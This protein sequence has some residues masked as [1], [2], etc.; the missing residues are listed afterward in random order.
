MKYFCCDERRRQ[1]V[2][3]SGTLNGIDYI[4]V[5]DHD[6][7]TEALR[8]RTLFVKFLKP[9]PGLDKN[10]IIII[11]GDR[12]KTVEIEWIAP[13][14]NLPGGEDA[15]IVDGLNAFELDYFLVVR[16]KYYGDFSLYTLRLVS[17]PG[18][19]VPPVGFDPLLAELQFS[20]K[21]ECESDFDC[22]VKTICPPEPA[23]APAI[24]YLAKDYLSFRRLM[25]DRMA[26]LI[27]QW[28]ERNP[29]DL[30]IALVEVL[31]YV[32][33]YLSYQQDAIATEAYLDTARRRVSVRRHARLV[34]Y[35]MHDGCN[36][37][38]WVRVYIV[39]DAVPLPQGT[40]L[41]TRVSGLPE[42]FLPDGPEWREALARR[43][44]VF[45]TV[46]DAILYA[47]HEEFEFYTWGQRGCCLPRGATSATLKGQFPTLKAGDVLIFV[48][49]ASP[50]TGKAADADRTHRCAV[51]L[52]HVRLSEDPSGGLFEQPPTPSATPVTEIE[53]D[54]DDALPFPLCI[55]VA[56]NESLKMSVAYGNVVLAD[57]GRKIRDEELGIVTIPTLRYAPATPPV[58]C[59]KEEREAVPPRFR[60]PLK[61]QPITHTLSL[62]PT[63]LFQTPVTA[64]LLADLTALMFSALIGDWFAS[65]GF[66]FKK[67]PVVVQGGDEVWSLSDGDSVYL[68]R[69]IS[70]DLVVYARQGSAGRALES[71]PHDARPAVTLTGTRDGNTQTWLPR[72]D[73]LGSTEDAT[74][75]VVDVENDGTASIRFGDDVHGKRPDEGT[76]F[77]ATYRVG[78]GAAGNV[79]AES[80]V[81]VA[82]SDMHIV[83]VSNP[84]SAQGGTEPERL[85]EVRRDAPEAFRV[86]QR[87]VT[88]ADYAEMAERHRRVQRAAATLRWTGSWHTVFV[89]VD[90]RGGSEVDADFEDEL[91]HHLERYRMAGY[92]LEVD[93]PR[94]VPLEV[95]V[96]VCVKPDY[97]RG[98]VKQ[99][100]LSVLGSGLLADGRRGLFHA[101]NFTFGQPVY[102]SQIYTAAQAVE[103]VD[104]VFVETFQRLREPGTEGLDDGVLPMGRLEIARLDNDP[105]FP[106]R[107][108]L[109]LTLGGG[110]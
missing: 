29:A 101:D 80:I 41:L 61:E 33:D 87:A 31:A 16:T 38:T 20:F 36:A 79:G 109:K 46:D 107:G 15:T 86:Q 93:G 90:R 98:H 77:T 6:A 55:S 43:A 14:D 32:G 95:E 34:D 99:T 85:E 19:D 82:S 66:V 35:L 39:G 10:Q 8:Q 13:A 110:M 92:D 56:E 81:H 84:L 17:D 42:R 71:I 3:E 108:V 104:S 1:V 7:P 88:P 47:E 96:R 76:T 106:E 44:L 12:I 74:E 102:L 72:I 89:T 69:R 40:P 9:N 70:D 28:K 48:E 62:Q 25:L 5:L 78:N 73:L 105:N 64:Q 49:I 51:R 26:L 23:A 4:E 67:S 75:F 97:F 52:T 83:A 24:D 94:F 21:V 22:A 50:T 91:R 63:V 37:R 2:K 68:V 18:S 30:G 45:E 65:H 60:P 103:G 59:E 53:W 27:P 57:H 54:E 11:G 100:L 58:A